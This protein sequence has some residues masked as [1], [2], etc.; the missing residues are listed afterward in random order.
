MAMLFNAMQESPTSRHYVLDCPHAN[1][2][3][4]LPATDGSKDAEVLAN[5]VKQVKRSIA[6]EVWSGRAEEACDCQPQGWR[7]V[8]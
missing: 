7:G 4:H 1:L 8:R 2:E 5:M 3:L 6:A